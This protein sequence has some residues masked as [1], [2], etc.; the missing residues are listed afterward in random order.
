M[1]PGVFRICDQCGTEKSRN[2]NF[3]RNPAKGDGYSAIC[4]ACTTENKHV[5]NNPES[6]AIQPKFSGNR[7]SGGGL[8][9]DAYWRGHTSWS[10]VAATGQKWRLGLWTLR[11]EEQVVDGLGSTATETC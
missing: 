5:R 10:E 4:R 1:K 11:R 7:C 9:L 2:L 6:K 8:L 3:N